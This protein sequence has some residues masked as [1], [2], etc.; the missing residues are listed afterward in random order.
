MGVASLPV[1]NQIVPADD[2]TKRTADEIPAQHTD[3]DELELHQDIISLLH[4]RTTR[5]MPLID[6]FHAV[7]NGSGTR[8]T[9]KRFGHSVSD[10]G[11]KIIYDTLLAYSRSS[12][13]RHLESLLTKFRDFRATQADPN[14]RRS[15]RKAQPAKP[16]I[17]FSPQERD[18]RSIVQVIERNGGRATLAR[19]GSQRS[20][21]L[22]RLPRDP[23]S[24][25]KTRLH[26]VLDQMVKA[27]VL[28]K[29]GA[30]YIPGKLRQ[31]FG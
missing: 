21:W 1:K 6:L 11:R 15:Q 19:L 13:N 31:V 18:F 20:R 7:L 16:Q 9:R 2:P 30:T 5:D 29:Q 17:M 25:H 14:S 12:G 3:H 24:P 10:R 23:S 28:A 4:H 27:G 22:G 26:D 8:E